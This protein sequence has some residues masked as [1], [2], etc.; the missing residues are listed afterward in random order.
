MSHFEPSKIYDVV[1]KALDYRSLRQDLISSNIANISTPFYRPRDVD[2]EE[3]LSKEAAKVLH[4]GPDMTLHLAQTSK[5]HL[6]SNLLNN[7]KGTLFFR[8]GHLARND[9]N[10][11]DLD[12]ETSEMS[13]NGIMYQA[14]IS[15]LKKDKGIFTY[16]VESSK[17]L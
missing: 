1:Y 16:A 8:D 5:S 13:K 10:S 11:V 14:L 4:K 17:G 6:K 12:V 9:G 7:D 15:A 2:F 3:M